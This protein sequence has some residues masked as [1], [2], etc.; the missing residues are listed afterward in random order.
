VSAPAADGPVLPAGRSSLPPGLLPTAPAPAVGERWLVPVV[1][2]LAL[3]VI[4]LLGPAQPTYDP[5]AWIIWGREITQ[6]DLVTTFG[7][8]WK[9]LPVLFTTPFALLGDAVA[10]AA[11]LVVARAGG[12]MAI[13]MAYRLA[14]RL[15]GRPAGVIAGAALLLSED[16]VRHFARGNSEGLLVALCLSAVALHLDGRRTPAFALGFGAA[17]LRPEVWPFFGLYGLWLALREP[18]RRLLVLG[19]FIATAV[20][21][22]LPEYLGSGNLLRAAERAREANADSAAF[23]ERPF[24]EVLRRAAG[25]LPWPVWAG[26]VVAL[27]VALGTRRGTRQ[28]RT[29]L[30]LA[31]VA[32]V[33]MAGV[34]LMTE[35][36][37]AGNLRYVAL[38]V[39]LVCVLA[40]AGWTWLVRDL[41]AR[42]GPAVAT[43]A[44]ATLAIVSMPS[45]V[46]AA[47]AF[48]DSLAD[49]RLEAE[50]YA[51]LDRA[52]AASGGAE[53][54]VRCGRVI[55]GPFE[56]QA[57]AWTL[58]RHGAQID[59]AGKPPGTVF[60]LRTH[61]LAADERFEAEATTKHWVVKRA[62]GR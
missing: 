13:F 1:A 32:A 16:F 36:G 26:G 61:P 57:L 60:A 54:S 27:G 18:R 10:P 49:L 50:V 59:I 35:A 41:H 58:G 20:L 39:A 56:V 12:L 21:W 24:L 47:G 11:W 62:C 15:G 38:P 14:A 44:A 46:V 45:A 37:F 29:V 17:L 55:T 30:I 53:A 33:L 9:P 22:F 42:R 31:A 28:R 23:A 3:S 52:I 5:W 48:A 25:L 2:C 40:G 19:A 51:D 4:S 43:A 34:G 8:S 6:G 7:P